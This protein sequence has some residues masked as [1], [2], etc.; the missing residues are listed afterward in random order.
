MVL[1][2]GKFFHEINSSC[3]TP[4]PENGYRGVG[5]VGVDTVGVYGVYCTC[6]GFRWKVRF[7]TQLIYS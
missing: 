3:S 6:C 7:N 5:V 2:F 1:V 4:A